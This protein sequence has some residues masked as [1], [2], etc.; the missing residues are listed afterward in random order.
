MLLIHTALLR[1][2]VLG[3]GFRYWVAHLVNSLTAIRFQVNDLNDQTAAESR[4]G[5]W[6]NE[7][8]CRWYAGWLNRCLVLGI[9]GNYLVDNW[10]VLPLLQKPFNK[11]M[12]AGLLKEHQ[13]DYWINNMSN[14]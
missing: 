7:H 3:A 6:R 11:K 9:G 12:Y 14:L 1:V 13:L 10:W 5:K 8:Q 4:Y 2:S